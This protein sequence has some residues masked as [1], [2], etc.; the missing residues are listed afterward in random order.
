MTENGQADAAKKDAFLN[1]P[2]QPPASLSLVSTNQSRSTARS[3]SQSRPRPSL[4][5]T[6][7]YVDAHGTYF[8][9]RQPET[10]VKEK[11]DVDVE[12]SPEK[13]F[14]VD[15][16]GPDDPLNPRNMGT[17]RKWLVVIILAFGSLCVTCTSSLYT[18]TYTQMDAEFGNSRIVATLGLSLF[19][20]GL[21][22]SPMILGP[23][24]EFYGRRPMQ[25]SLSAKSCAGFDILIGFGSVNNDT[26]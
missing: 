1:V 22:L 11:S 6:R 23:L 26:G 15:W 17:G 25:V 19:V 12:K 20:F 4:Y 10:P 18:I 21:G 14:E 9:E 7:S 13:N 8:T 3:R 16:D 5:T 2:S 24:S